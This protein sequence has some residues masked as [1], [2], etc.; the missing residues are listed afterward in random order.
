MAVIEAVITA[1]VLLMSREPGGGGG[2]RPGLGGVE[3][4]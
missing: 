4:V 1:A 3:A 2:L